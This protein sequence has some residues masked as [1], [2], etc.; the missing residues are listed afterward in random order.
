VRNEGPARVRPDGVD[1]DLPWRQ[2]RRVIARSN[3]CLSRGCSRKNGRHADHRR[4]AEQPE[5]SHGRIRD[6]S[7]PPLA[8][9]VKRRPTDDTRAGPGVTKLPRGQS[10]RH[11]LLPDGAAAPPPAGRGISLVP[12]S[13]PTLGIRGIAFRGLRP[14]RPV[15]ETLVGS[16]RS[17]SSP[18]VHAFITVVRQWRRERLRATGPKGRRRR[19]IA[20]E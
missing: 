16:R 20:A 8:G 12:A 14:S 2:D 9:F 3:A 7:L 5:A 17:E 13:F 18:V 19:M 15:L 11:R 1:I 6:H 4:E 10:K